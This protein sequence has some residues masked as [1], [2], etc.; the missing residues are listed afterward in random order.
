MTRTKKVLEGGSVKVE[1]GENA[2]ERQGGR[3]QQQLESSRV[4]TESPLTTVRFRNSPFNTLT[5][6]ILTAAVG[7]VA[8]VAATVLAVRFR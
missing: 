8:S 2:N 1:E 6:P 7:Y 3:Q 5:G 4:V